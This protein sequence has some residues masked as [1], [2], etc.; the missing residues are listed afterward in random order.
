MFLFH[1]LPDLDDAKSYFHTF[2][3]RCSSA[4]TGWVNRIVAPQTNNGGRSTVF[5]NR[6]TRTQKKLTSIVVFS[7][8]SGCSSFLL[9]QLFMPN[10]SHRDEIWHKTETSALSACPRRTRC[11]Q[12]DVDKLNESLTEVCCVSKNGNH[13]RRVPTFAQTKRKRAFVVK[14]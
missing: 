12:A 2:P 5:T 6:Q 7:A 1:T 9:L 11:L 13:F 8:E 14:L 4:R 10:I 3:G